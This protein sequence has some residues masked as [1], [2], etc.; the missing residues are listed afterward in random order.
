MP[1]WE[2]LP[3]LFLGDRGDAS[4]RDRLRKRGVT[5]IVNCSK[6]LSC[7][8]EGEFQY[9]WL[10]MEDPDPAFADKVETFCAFIDAGR[11]KAVDKK[12]GR[13]SFREM[14]CV[15][16]FLLA[17]RNSS[18]SAGRSFSNTVLPLWSSTCVNMVLAC[19]STPQ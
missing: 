16:F 4:D 13:T 5:H 18:G 9:L 3:D 6:E 10:R 11:K 14:S 17:C 1:L 8:F 19:R 7:H 12:R 2:I 15:P